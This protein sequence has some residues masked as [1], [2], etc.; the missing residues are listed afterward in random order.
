MKML[1]CVKNNG[2]S[3]HFLIILHL[4]SITFHSCWRHC[5]LE[6][7]T[8]KNWL[9]GNFLYQRFI[10][11]QT[12]WVIAQPG[13]K[14]WRPNDF[15]L[16][17]LNT[18]HRKT[19]QMLRRKVTVT[20]QTNRAK[21]WGNIFFSH[22]EN[23]LLYC[24]VKKGKWSSQKKFERNKKFSLP[25][26]HPI[27]QTSAEAASV[28]GFFSRNGPADTT[29]YVCICLD[30]NTYNGDPKTNG[31]SRNQNLHSSD[32][33]GHLPI[34]GIYYRLPRKKASLIMRKG[35]VLQIT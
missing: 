9:A 4:I 14:H 10:S 26:W 19:S 32:I 22:W 17:P 28:T 25:S 5:Q 16:C 15:H 18:Q 34:S 20:T 24:F 21:A 30:S 27:P 33:A 23:C 3:F 8:E 1:A 12:D 7:T 31:L 35:N 2:L 13:F 11:L 29:T 6:D